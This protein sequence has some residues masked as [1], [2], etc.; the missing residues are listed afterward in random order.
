MYYA[1]VKNNNVERVLFSPE[2]IVS[3]D[4]TY[5]KNIFTV[6]SVDELIAIGIYPYSEVKDDGRFYDFGSLSYDIQ[7]KE[8]VGTYVSTAKN[9]DDIKEQ[10]INDVKRTASQY[11]STGDWLAIREYEGGDTI[12]TDVKTKRSAV[13]AE[14]N[15]KEAEI[16]TLTTITKIKNYDT[17]FVSLPAE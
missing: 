1:I 11:L 4:V 9:L 3:N 17:D 8:V 13:R 7:A 10:M 15:T 2:S 6:W 5:P 12:P 14:S 16:N